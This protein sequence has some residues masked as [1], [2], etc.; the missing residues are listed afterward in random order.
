MAPRPPHLSLSGFILML[1]LFSTQKAAADKSISG[2]LNLCSIRGK[3]R[4]L[5]ASALLRIGY[6]GYY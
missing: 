1:A 2:R 4:T 5:S 3:G 6:I